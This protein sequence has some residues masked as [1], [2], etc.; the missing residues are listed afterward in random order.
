MC[1]TAVFK[2]YV[3]KLKMNK[4]F[5]ILLLLVFICTPF[6]QACPSKTKAVHCFMKKGDFNHDG[7][8]DKHEMTKVEQKYISFWLR[9]PYRMF[10]GSAQIFKDCDTNKDGAISKE[11]ATT[12]KTCLEGCAKIDRVYNTLNC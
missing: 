4:T 1:L 7:K 10:G 12:S 11:E 2:T 8:I 9:I 6:V 3:N 5:I